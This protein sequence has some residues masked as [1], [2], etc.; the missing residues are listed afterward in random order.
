MAGITHSYCGV[1]SL[2]ISGIKGLAIITSYYCNA[3]NFR[4]NNIQ[5]TEIGTILGYNLSQALVK[6]Q[7]HQEVSQQDVIL[8]F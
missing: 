4:N 5:K 6:Q 2:S 8:F 3:K 1:N 7:F